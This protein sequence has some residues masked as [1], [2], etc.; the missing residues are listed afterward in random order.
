MSTGKEHNE[1]KMIEMEPICT[2][3]AASAAVTRTKTD[4]DEEVERDRREQ[5]AFTISMFN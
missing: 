4:I 2:S 1:R 5:E 3:M